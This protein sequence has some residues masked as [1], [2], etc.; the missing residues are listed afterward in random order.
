MNR[1]DDDDTWAA[2]R[3]KVVQYIKTLP[4]D[5]QQAAFET[6]GSLL[7]GRTDGAAAQS[8]AFL[9][10]DGAFELADNVRKVWERVKAMRATPVYG[11]RQ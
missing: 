10:A 8:I 3:D 11:P 4:D 7:Q 2:E 9:E 6:Y 1:K 5:Q